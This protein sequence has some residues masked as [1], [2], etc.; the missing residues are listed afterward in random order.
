MAKLNAKSTKIHD[1]FGDKVLNVITTI[2]LI[3]IILII[4]YP[5]L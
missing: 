1:T 3:L 5:I 4:G 2:L